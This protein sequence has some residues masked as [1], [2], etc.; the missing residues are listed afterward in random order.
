M[1]TQGQ[2]EAI[3]KEYEKRLEDFKNKAYDSKQFMKAHKFFD[4]EPSYIE[5]CNAYWDYRLKANR[6]Q[7]R[8]EMLK[9][10]LDI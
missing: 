2:I 1:K 10:V 3:L 6:T 5:A 7:A 8:I 4:D 9:W